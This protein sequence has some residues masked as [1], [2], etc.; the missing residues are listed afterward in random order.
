M[1]FGASHTV[2]DSLQAS[3]LLSDASR[4]ELNRLVGL[5]TTL[6]VGAGRVLTSQ[7]RRGREFFL[8]VSGVASCLVD[9]DRVA[10]FG[11]GDFFGELS[12]LTDNP[13][14]ATVIADTDMDLVVFSAQEF[15]HLLH[16]SPSVAAQMVDRLANRVRTLEAA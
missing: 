8:V 9:G 3:P 11:P 6:H 14:T 15:D 16:G 2:I 5:G 1:R 7:G 10:E 12:L 13:R 4:G